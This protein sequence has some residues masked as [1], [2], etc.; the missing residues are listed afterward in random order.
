MN[1]PANLSSITLNCL[2]VLED[3]GIPQDNW[4]NDPIKYHNAP[5]DFNN[6]SLSEELEHFNTMPLDLLYKSTKATELA[7]AHQ[8]KKIFTLLPQFREYSVVFEPK[9]SEGFPPPCPYDHKID[10]KTD[11][12]PILFKACKLLPKETT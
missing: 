1:C 12:K 7:Q 5:S 10:L 8:T 2:T 11:F 6:F 3:Q 4:N 9:K